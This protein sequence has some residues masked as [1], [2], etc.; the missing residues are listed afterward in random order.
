[1]KHAPITHLKAVAD[2]ARIHA[3][4]KKLREMQSVLERSGLD[5]EAKKLNQ[6]IYQC[7]VR[8]KQL[9]DEALEQRKALVRE[10]LLCFAAGDIATACADN[11]AGIFDKVT[12]GD[13]RKGGH[14]LAEIFR[15]QAEQWNKCVQIVDGDGEEHGNTQISMY[16]AD[17][18]EKIVS[19]TLPVIY[20]IIDDYMNSEK[21]KRLL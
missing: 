2:G 1:M 15:H 11:V 14:A 16:Y 20:S 6:P 13:I 8:I 10:L 19:T 7:N 4:L 3:E 5:K 18:A 21:G 17:M 9:Q 12:Y